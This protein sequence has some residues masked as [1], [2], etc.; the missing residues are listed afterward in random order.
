ML[1]L[2]F[3][4][5][6]EC[7][8]M[9]SINSLPSYDQIS[10][11]LD[12][13]SLA[14]EPAECHGALSGFLCAADDFDMAAWV[15]RVLLPKEAAAPDDAPALLAELSQQE[16]SHL[17]A[18]HSETVRQLQDPHFGFNLLLPD[19]EEPLT[20]RA[21]LLAI[22]CQGFVLGLSAGG[23]NDFNLL[24]QEA[25]EIINDIVEIS[26]LAHHETEGTE[27]DETAYFEVAE[28]IRM[29]VLLIHA[30]LSKD[31]TVTPEQRVLH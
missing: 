24:P 16:T 7:A 14:L 6:A 22:W 10:A 27:E 9:T 30:E 15:S 17:I 25:S 28:Y 19:D 21:E 11:V 5:D 26:R 29:G 13:L 3:S 12:R 4:N 18:L 1:P 8:V 20:T 2:S 31:Q 23:V